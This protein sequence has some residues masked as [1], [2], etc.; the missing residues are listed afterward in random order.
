MYFNIYRSG[1]GGENKKINGYM[2][3]IVKMDMGISM[4]MGMIFENKYE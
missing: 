1:M 3:S 2:T 4:R